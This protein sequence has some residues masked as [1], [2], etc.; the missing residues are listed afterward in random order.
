VFSFHLKFVRRLDSYS[1]F[2]EPVSEDEAPDYHEVIKNPMDFGTMRTKVDSGAYG[3]GSDAVLG[4]YNDFMLVF[5]NC[6]RYNDEDG[7]VGLEAS[8]MLGLLPEVFAEACSFVAGKQKKQ[9]AKS[10]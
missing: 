8:R 9:K 3:R 4:L 2:T 10:S 6:A 7:E 5:D 1:L